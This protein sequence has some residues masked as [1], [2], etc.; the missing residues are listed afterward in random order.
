[1][2]VKKKAVKKAPA[3]KAPAK[4]APAKKAAVKKAPAK[5]AVANKAPAQKKKYP[6]IRFKRIAKSNWEKL[7]PAS[8]NF[9]VL[10]LSNAW[11]DRRCPV[12]HHHG[13]TRRSSLQLPLQGAQ[14]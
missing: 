14:A 3:K 5:K 10:D 8:P 11:R 4:K 13:T 1:M 12:R 2:P 9:F 7:Q 6:A